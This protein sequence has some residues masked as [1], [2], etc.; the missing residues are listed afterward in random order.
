MP[1]V[2]FQPSQ[3]CRMPYSPKTWRSTLPW[4]LPSGVS[5]SS[6]GSTNLQFCHR[7]NHFFHCIGINK[8]WSP[9]VTLR[10][11]TG[12][13]SVLTPTRQALFKVLSVTPLSAHTHGFSPYSHLDPH[14]HIIVEVEIWTGKHW[15]KTF[16]MIDSGC[17]V[18]VID[19]RFAATLNI[20]PMFKSQ[21]IKY[22]MVDGEASAGGIVT[23]DITTEIK[24]GPHQELL[25]FDITKLHSYPIMLGI[26]WLKQ[27]DPWI[28]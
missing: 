13:I 15:T 25:T 11:S 5:A 6:R 10:P 28:Q 3:S 2:W 17:T 7:L 19:S 16:V 8:W 1:L 14:L 21:T 12:A 22:T 26:P 4:T 24:V 20:L 27:H 23:H 18:N 9:R